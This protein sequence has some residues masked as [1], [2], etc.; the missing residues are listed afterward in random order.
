LNNIYPNLG[1]SN[2]EETTTMSKQS[3]RKFLIVDD[4]EQNRYMLQV[5]L[6]GHGYGVE[7]ANNGAE[8][9]EKARR[10]PPNMVISDIL[11][12]E[13]DGFTLCRQWKKDDVLKTIPFIFYTATYTDPKDEQF[14][15]SL[16]ADRFIAKPVEPDVFID[17]ILQVLKVYQEGQFISLH[18]PVE[19][20]ETYL[21]K[22]NKAL[23]RKL[24]DKVKALEES[25]QALEHEITERKGAE[26]ALQKAHDELE[27]LVE[28]RTAE[29]HRANAELT[30]SARLKDEFLANM[31]HEL[32]T[33]LNAIL[34]MSEALQE[35]VYG[36][37]ND[38]QRKSL[39]TIE[40][41]GRHLLTLINDI[42]DL[43]KIGAGKLE[44]T[45]DSV[46]VEAIC[47]AS[48]RFIKQTAQKK[49][50]RVSSSFDNRVTSMLAD[51]RRLKQIL[52]NLLSNAVKFTPEGREVGLKVEGDPK[53]QIVYFTV[54]DT[55]IGIA[56]EDME[57]LFQPFVQLDATLSRQYE[58]AGLGLS[59]VY[60]MVE[61]HGGSLKVES[62]VGKGT[63]FT[64]SL[65]WKEL[66]IPS[67]SQ[68]GNYTPLSPSRGELELP[69]S[70]TPQ[71]ATR[72]SQPAIRTIL[73]AEDNE[74]NIQTLSE[75]LT[76]KGYRLIIARNGRDAIEYTK[77]DHPDIVLMD[78]RM[79]IMNGY[80]AILQIRADEMTRDIPIIAVTALVMP[81]DRERC[82]NAGA[83]K[84]LSKPVS[85][86]ELNQMIEHFLKKGNLT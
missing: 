64:V 85:L 69:A 83:D 2:K 54:W 4:D 66:P 14:A 68:E 46:S 10:D 52:V 41:S 73:I 26:E 13:M 35:E 44:L 43:S 51:R 56:Q 8:A 30:R 18:E 81:G 1:L 65:P 60:S 7:L 47:E 39:Q 21:R 61:I 27:K 45:L 55:G 77:T 33:P 34:G 37:V 20:E 24:E 32:R 50:L 53:Q 38:K 58:G 59:L 40:E 9:L 25:N 29:L 11:M 80:D 36:V 79:P 5:L 23:I 84:Y 71:P 31:S 72:N 70:D 86:Q 57:R 28:E 49:R 76:A 48:L 15:L 67:P 63:R 82:L 42:L 75:Y 62:D 6:Q 74:H 3:V 12:P 16:G 19:E 78:I 22:Y 17:L